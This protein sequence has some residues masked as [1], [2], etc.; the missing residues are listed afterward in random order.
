MRATGRARDVGHDVG[1]EHGHEAAL[2]GAG[3]VR[4]RGFLDVVA[5]RRAQPR[6]VFDRGD[7]VRMDGDAGRRAAREADAQPARADAPTSSSQGRSGGAAAYGSPGSG[8]AIAS[9]IAA[10]SRTLRETTC[11]IAS[12][13]S[14][15]PPSGPAVMRARVGFRPNR[16]QAD[17]GMRIE[18]PPSVA[19]AIGT[20]PAATAAAEPP[21]EPPGARSSCQGLRVTP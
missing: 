1:A 9:S 18:P 5:E 2:E 16:P 14:P 20:M 19:W 8:P 11:W 13:L 3:V 7:A 6:G 17:A 21:L 10:L 12:P 15:S 4:R